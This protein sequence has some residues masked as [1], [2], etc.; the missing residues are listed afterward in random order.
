MEVV[1]DFEG[2]SVPL[3]GPF[4]GLGFRESAALCFSRVRQVSFPAALHG[5]RLNY[6]L[7]VLVAANSGLL[8]EP[9]TR[10]PGSFSKPKP[11]T[12][13]YHFSDT[14]RLTGLPVVAEVSCPR[15]GHLSG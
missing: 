14:N 11:V 6:V 15:H 12:S 7:V 5:M 10:R 1:Q 4:D 3:L 2:F 9:S 8:K 13:G